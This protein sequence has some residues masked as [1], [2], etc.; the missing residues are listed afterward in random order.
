WGNPFVALWDTETGRERLEVRG[1]R[2]GVNDLAFSPDGK[3]LAAAGRDG[4][5]Y[6]WDAATGKPRLEMKGHRGE[7][8]ALAFSARGDALAVAAGTAVR[9]YDP[10]NGRVQKTFEAAPGWVSG[11]ALSPDG[12]VVTAVASA[13]PAALNEHA[14]HLWDRDTGKRL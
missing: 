6:L 4:V 7:V 3:L 8:K 5:A 13:L 12:R 1:P 2:T 14:V 10:S 11:V 9:L